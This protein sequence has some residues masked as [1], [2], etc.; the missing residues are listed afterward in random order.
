MAKPK[1]WTETEAV[2][3]LTSRGA[4]V[5]GNLIKIDGCLGGLSGGACLDYLVNYRGYKVARAV[6]KEPFLKRIK[7]FFG[8]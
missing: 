1:R 3:L 2:A 5:K 7:K 8:R 4:E 6:E